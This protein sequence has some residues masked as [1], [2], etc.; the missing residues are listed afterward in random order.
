MKLI[1]SSSENKIFDLSI[2]EKSICKIYKKGNKNQ[3]EFQGIGFFCNF[4]IEAFPIKYA[5][6]T[7]YNILKQKDTELGKIIFFNYLNI[8]KTIKL[9]GDRKIYTN[10]DLNYTCIEIF[11]SD[12]IENYFTIK[13]YDENKNYSK[14]RDI[15]T[16]QYNNNDIS[17][18]SGKIISINDKTIIH[19]AKSEIECYGSPI[20]RKC[21]NIILGINLARDEKN[22][23]NNL[24]TT[25]E[26]ILNDISNRQYSGIKKET[27]NP[28]KDDLFSY[29]NQSQQNEMNEIYCI[30]KKN[31]KTINLMYDY[32]NNNLYYRSDFT[33]SRKTFE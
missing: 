14:E 26:S 32:K 3:N 6:F 17:F 30:Y 25:F 27:I 4:E 5:L 24:E 2:I 1:N 31:G 7:S 21:N 33:E 22:Y 23:L 10:E 20:I 18:F 13:S 29:K 11:N 16:I 12:N 28:N 19:N 9:V 15:F 8:E